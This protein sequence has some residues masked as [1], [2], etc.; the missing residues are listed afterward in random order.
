MATSPA[1]RILRLA[2]YLDAHER[3][4]VTLSDITRD[5]PGYADGQLEVGTTAWE[6]A[7]KKL[8]RDIKD[9]DDQLGIEVL[10]DEA[11]HCYRLAPP[12]LSA[13]ERAALISAAAVVTV[14][15]LQALEPGA[16]GSGVDDGAARV[17]VQVHALVAGFRDAISTRTPMRF[18]H[19]GKERVV[20]PWA[21]GVWHNKWY[22]AGGDPTRNHVMRRFRLD[23]VDTT[24]GEPLVA[25]G[26]PGS[27][28]VPGD[29]D[30]VKAFD[31]DPN[32]WGGDA[33]LD[34]RVRVELVHVDPFRA[35]FGGEEVK[36]N[37][38]YARIELTVRHYES[39]VNRLLRF[40]GHAVVESPPELVATVRE[41]LAATADAGAR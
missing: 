1:E 38:E 35:E 18:R 22:V 8:Q 26:E 7:R 20:E 31:F 37:K 41:H 12:F 33:P 11:D 24:V 15:G 4:H 36:R 34:A 21:L 32:S 10:Y 28:E 25:A 27:Y 39:F 13:R 29:F 3:D 9:L 2:A 16:I 19:E 23:R 40:R 6:S 17:V 30:V 14:D 5:L